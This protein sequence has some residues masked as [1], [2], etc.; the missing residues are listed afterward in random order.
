MVQGLGFRVEHVAVQVDR[1][2]CWRGGV[3]EA[4][5]RGRPRRGPSEEDVHELA[6][7]V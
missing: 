3:K 7:V 6:E 5:S 4:E 1:G 2:E